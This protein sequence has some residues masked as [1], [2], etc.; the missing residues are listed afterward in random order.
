MKKRRSS[1][2]RNSSFEPRTSTFSRPLHSPSVL[3]ALF[4]LDLAAGL[5]LFLPLVGRRNAGVKF[6]RLVLIVSGALAVGV[7]VARPLWIDGAVI[8]ALTVFVYLTL[9]YP[10]R[11]V[12]RIPAALLG[13]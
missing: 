8:L 11:L 5:Y 6:Y 3:L 2:L 13:G 9:R 10:K 12:F 1:R 4:L 7:A